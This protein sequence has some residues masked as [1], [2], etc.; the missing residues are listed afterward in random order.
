[1]L[2]ILVI[3]VIY[4]LLDPLAAGGQLLA[5]SGELLAAG[6]QLGAASHII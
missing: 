1:M 6:G 4:F 2:V 5:A 3:L